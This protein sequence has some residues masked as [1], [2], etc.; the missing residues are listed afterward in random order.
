MQYE[1]IVP[2]VVSSL[3]FIVSF[4]SLCVSLKA[5][6]IYKEKLRLDLYNK[7]FDIYSKTLNYSLIFISNRKNYKILNLKVSEIAASLLT[8]NLG[9][10]SVKILG[11][12][13]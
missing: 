2:I 9:T 8:E 7:R 13:T 11:F 5:Q 10:Y 6:E 12:T 1:F 4:A 3:S